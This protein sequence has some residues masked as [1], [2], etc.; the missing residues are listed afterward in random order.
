MGGPEAIRGYLFQ[1]ILAILDSFAD[2]EWTSFKLE[3]DI[4]SEKVDIF[5]NYQHQQKM[6]QVKSSINQI[7]IR[8]VKK[9]IDELNLEIPNSISKELRLIG[10]CLKE[11]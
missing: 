3:P 1:T 7:N 10:L 2:E 9:W 8:H 5:W 6:V 4:E 11:L